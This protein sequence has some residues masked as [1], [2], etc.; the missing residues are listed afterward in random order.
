MHHPGK[1]LTDLAIT[2]ALGG[3]CLANVAVLRAEP[4]VYGPVASD[5]TV[6]RTI[7]ALAA[8]VDAALAAINRA[9]ARARERVWGLAGE[10]APDAGIDAQTPLV[11]DVD[12][13][14]VTAHSDK[15]QARPTFKRGFGFH[16][17]WVFADHGSQGS[18]EPLA[19]LLLPGN[20]GSNTAV[21]HDR[22]IRDALAQLP[23]H[24]PG[25]R[26][27][28]SVLV[29]ADGAGGTHALVEA[30]TRQRL[31]YSVGFSLADNTPELLERIPEQVWAPAYDADGQVREGGGW[32]S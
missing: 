11:L 19:V 30:L 28:R 31:S 27:G 17:L 15:E 25:G 16:P 12:G 29:R 2:L 10:H 13:T 23:G 14:L 24:R 18:G 20:A 26:A 9:R 22:V 8:D 7:D 1:V 4:A 21:D 32:P 3:D 6:S 5:P